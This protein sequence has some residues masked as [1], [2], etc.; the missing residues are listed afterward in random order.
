MQ[1][2]TPIVMSRSHA[3]FDLPRAKLDPVYAAASASA[4]FAPALTDNLRVLRRLALGRKTALWH[5]FFAPNPRTSTV[6]RVVGRVRRARSVQTVCSAPAAGVNL[7]QVLF[8]ERVVVLSEHT[9]RRFLDAGVSEARVVLIRPAIAPLSPVTKERA[10]ELRHELGLA[11]ERPLIVYAG[12]LEFGRGADLA[13]E[14]HRDLPAG[15]D[16]QLV[17]ACREKT[18]R[19]RER[20]R[21]LRERAAELGI[22]DRVRFMGETPRIHDLLAS[23]DL[24]TMPTETL[25]AKMDL[26]LV[27]LEAMALSRCVLV[28]A[29][30]PAQELAAAGGAAKVE[31]TREAVSALT[32]ELILDEQRRATLGERARQVVL[33]DYSPRQMAERYEALY[34]QLCA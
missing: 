33:E 13:L 31:T 32:R 26:P 27:L 28:G 5:F 2:Y 29:G 11:V 3:A 15:L 6:A 17:L 21:L 12:D 9:R 4:G 10:R 23:A 14:A 7:K 1:R 30:T 25:Y 34:D 22:A 16:A 8:A 19:A 20:A 24:V 18:P